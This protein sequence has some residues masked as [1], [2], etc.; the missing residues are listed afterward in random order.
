MLYSLECA[1]FER[2]V[3]FC[4]PLK[5]EE[6]EE[7]MNSQKQMKQQAQTQM[8]QRQQPTTQS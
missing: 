5:V 3:V 6:E 4:Q 7:M 2:S 8:S 1:Q